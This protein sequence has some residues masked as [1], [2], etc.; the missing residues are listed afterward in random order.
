VGDDFK[1]NPN[2]KETT[3]TIGMTRWKSKKELEGGKS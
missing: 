2:K 1:K 3:I